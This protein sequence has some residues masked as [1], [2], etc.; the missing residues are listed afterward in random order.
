M[1]STRQDVNVGL[2]AFTG[3]VGTMVLF[4]IVLGVQA[5]FAYETDLI[6]NARYSADD[7]VDWR[8][9][10][11][12]QYANIGD[13]VGNDTIY[14]GQTAGPTRFAVDLGNNQS[15]RRD[16]VAGSDAALGYR[17]T[18]EERDQLVVPIHLA[19]AAFIKQRG[20]G[21][22]SAQEMAALD[23]GKNYYVHLTNNTYRDP[24]TYVDLAPS[25]TTRP[26]D[27][28][29]TAT[30]ADGSETSTGPAS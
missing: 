17:F 24:S 28:G 20:G 27:A 10:K 3:V 23:Q 13:T 2:V 30:G 11:S 12:E 25:P 15:E 16:Y 7:N 26:A 9:L 21:E 4:I 1:S 19:M 18:G 8:R 29:Q 5:W 22:I 6:I 14:A